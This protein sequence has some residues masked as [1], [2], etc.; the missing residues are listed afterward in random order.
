MFG[1]AYRM[2]YSWS[3]IFQRIKGL[4][5]T[6]KT[7]LPLESINTITLFDRPVEQ[8]FIQ[9]KCGKPSALFS[10]KV[11]I[12]YIIIV[13]FG[14]LMVLRFIFNIIAYFSQ[15]VLYINHQFLL[16]KLFIAKNKSSLDFVLICLK[17]IF[18]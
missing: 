10:N 12:V 6:S 13:P 14:C 5:G 8:N 7:V 9:H 11:H 18:F 17:A 16:Q 2:P 1:L 3:K 4:S 15:K